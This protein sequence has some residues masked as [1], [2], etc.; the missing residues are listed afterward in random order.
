MSVKTVQAM[1][2]KYLKLAGLESK[3]YSVH[4]L[5]HTAAT[6][7]ILAGATLLETQEHLRHASPNTTMIYIN[8]TNRAANT[9]AQ[10]IA[11]AIF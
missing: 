10:R 5:R 4:K 6:L 3:H 1:V 2:Y 8:E 9:S 11:A 7:A